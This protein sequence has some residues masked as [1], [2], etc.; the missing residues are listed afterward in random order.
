MTARERLLQAKEVGARSSYK[1]RDSLATNRVRSPRQRDLQVTEAMIRDNR[2]A[3]VGH[4]YQDIVRH[5]VS[6]G[7]R[8]N[9]SVAST[10]TTYCNKGDSRQEQMKEVVRC[11]KLKM[12]KAE[13]KEVPGWS[14]YRIMFRLAPLADLG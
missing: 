8:I 13:V 11:R 6:S 1:H 12:P 9:G 2:D 3:N 4:I 14:F 7:V 5:P 10:A